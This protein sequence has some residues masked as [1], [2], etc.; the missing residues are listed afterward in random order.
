M[1]EYGIWHLVFYLVFY[2][3]QADQKHLREIAG[4]SRNSVR[5][6]TLSSLE[7]EK[8]GTTNFFI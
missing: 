1:S 5:T 2:R 4:K 3:I 8:L 6:R 7:A